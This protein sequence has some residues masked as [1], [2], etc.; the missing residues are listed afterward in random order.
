MNDEVVKNLMKE[1]WSTPTQ[2]PL[3][4]TLTETVQS[5][6]DMV[7][8]HAKKYANS[9]SMQAITAAVVTGVT[10]FI[11]RPPMASSLQRGMCWAGFSALSVVLLS[12]FVTRRS[13]RGAITGIVGAVGLAG[14]A[15]TAASAVGSVVGHNGVGHDGGD[16]LTYQERREGVIEI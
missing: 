13:I 15:A 10:L 2:Q 1:T 9:T 4:P 8:M 6:P 16:G 12:N 11:L 3:H 7:E 5:V 14:A